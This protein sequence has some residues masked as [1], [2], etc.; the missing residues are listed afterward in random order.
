LPVAYPV[1]LTPAARS[2]LIQ[3]Q[4]WYERE[5]PGLG[6]RFRQAVDGVAQRVSDNPRQFPTVYRNVRR[7][8]MRR[9]PYAL[10]FVF[11]NETVTV[12]ACFHA[13]RDPL[14]WQERA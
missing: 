5:A 13:S 3:A 8:L 2:E 9:F 1:V 14:R 10:L 11:E 6:R 7:A 12:L 4:D